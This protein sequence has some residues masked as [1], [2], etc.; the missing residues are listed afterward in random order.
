MASGTW[1]LNPKDK[2]VD[3]QATARTLYQL[4]YS[5]LAW[6][7]FGSYLS[8]VWSART[9]PGFSPANYVFVTYVLF[10][11]IAAMIG[12]SRVRRAVRSGTMNAVQASMC[13]VIIDL[14]VI[15]A[16]VAL[17]FAQ[18]LPHLNK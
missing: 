16:Y 18:M 11:W 13:N 2:D 8:K 12:W 15:G 1:K 14:I 6:F 7:T 3:L 4:L 10:P 17:T 5:L 9:S